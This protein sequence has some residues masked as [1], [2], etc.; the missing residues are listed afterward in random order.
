MAPLE[1]QWVKVQQK[2]FTKWCASPRMHRA[3]TQLTAGCR[4]NS[5]LKTREVQI[6][7][8]ITDLSDG[9]SSP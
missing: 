8:L 3:G 6:D 9:V 7:D 5:K 2:T 1:Q 4:L